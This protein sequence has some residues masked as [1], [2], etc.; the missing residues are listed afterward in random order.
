MAG[1]VLRAGGDT[2]DVDGFLASSSFRPTAIYRRGERRH[3]QIAESRV[4]TSSGFNLT[5]SDDDGEDKGAKQVADALAFIEANRDELRRL[6]SR[7]DVE[8]C[9]DFGGILSEGIAAKY[10][11]LPIEIIRQCAALGIE[12]EVSVYLT[13][14]S[15]GVED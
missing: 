14:S 10:V 1:C 6:T 11:R 8:V 3:P 12:L 2:F 9:L 4:S 15:D 5:V 7:N 13:E